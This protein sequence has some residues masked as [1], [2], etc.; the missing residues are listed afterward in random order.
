MHRIVLPRPNT[1]ANARYDVKIRWT[2]AAPNNLRLLSE[3]ISIRDQLTAERN[4]I[5]FVDRKNF[6]GCSSLW[7]ATDLDGAP[8]RK[9]RRP[10]V[11]TRMKQT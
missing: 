4:E 2:L 11:A 6:D 10:I 8:P 5:A 1:P 7:S 3:E 9:A